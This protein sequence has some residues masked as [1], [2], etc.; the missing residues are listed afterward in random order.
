MGGK[1]VWCRTAPGP[2]E[3]Y[4]GGYAE[5]LA[6]QGFSPSRI[7]RRVDQ[8]GRLSHWLAIEGLSP[9]EFTM[10]Q[11]MRF[12]AARRA[13]GYRTFVS[14]GSLRVP[15]A[16]LRDVGVIAVP[17]VVVPEG[18]VERLLDDYRRY[19]AGE[20]GLVAHTIYHYER[21]ARLFLAGREQ[22]DGLGLERLAAQDVSAFLA[23]ECPKRSVSGARDLIK[24]LRALLRYLHIA[25]VIPAGA[26]ARGRALPNDQHE[27]LG[28][29][30]GRL[31]LKERAAADRGAEADQQLGEDRD[32]VSLGLRLKPPDDLAQ[33]PVIG[34]RGR[35]CR[36]A[37]RGAQRYPRRRR[38]VVCRRRRE[39]LEQRGHVLAHSA[40][41]SATAVRA[42]LSSTIALPSA[43]AATRAWTARLLTSLGRPRET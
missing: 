13:A 26:L 22:L 20:R 16:Y 15:V 38:G 30:A 25:G 34:S 3:A 32:R 6:A 23:C 40:W 1:P 17:A 5:W 4:A 28:V 27:L 41:T 21:V 39:L 36:P 8:L 12:S 35:R 10:E 37:R 7:E 43:N 19:L 31:D 29:M 33:Q 42:E 2:L 11:Q 9:D 18:P 24:G 14:P